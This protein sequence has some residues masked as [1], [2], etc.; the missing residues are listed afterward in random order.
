[1]KSWSEIIQH[2]GYNAGDVDGAIAGYTRVI[3]M[4]PSDPRAY[5]NR[6]RAYLDK[7]NYDA[8]IADMNRAI[9]LGS[10]IS[11]DAYCLRGTG[12]AGKGD[13]QKAIADSTTVIERNPLRFWGSVL[14]QFSCHE[15]FPCESR[16]KWG[17]T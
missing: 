2:A 4:S 16:R 14:Y 17:T 8:V 3:E 1:M 9:E 13:F 7:Q 6:G 11:A 12:W 15:E 10:P 5:F